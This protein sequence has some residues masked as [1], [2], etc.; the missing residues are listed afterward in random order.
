M[1]EGSEILK[2]YLLKHFYWYIFN[3]LFDMLH[4]K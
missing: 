2:H 1:D 4:M 3:K